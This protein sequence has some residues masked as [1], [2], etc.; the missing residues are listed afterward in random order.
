[1]HIRINER[2]DEDGRRVLFVEELQSDWGQKG[3]KQGFGKKLSPDE[4]ARI[5]DR[6][7]ELKEMVDG[8]L[9]RLRDEFPE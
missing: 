8:D 4:E 5:R 9:R 1:M 6:N 7:T 3:Q 2:I